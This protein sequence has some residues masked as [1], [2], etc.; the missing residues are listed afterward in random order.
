MAA[1]GTIPTGHTRLSPTTVVVMRIVGAV[2]LLAMGGIHF[3]LWGWDEYDQVP[4]IGPLFLIN[5]VVGV[6][7]AVA[8][9]VVP[10]RLLAIAATLSALFDLGTLFA[11]LVSIFWGLF[12]VHESF[13]YTIVTTTVI[14][15]ILG[16][17][18]LAV[19]ASVASKQAGMWTWLPEKS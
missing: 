8:I 12:G 3:F 17:A 5:A 4:I 19:L 1:S 11:L 9:C 13:Q 15:E 14:V 7:L 6:L 10:G 16:V 2:A 18:L